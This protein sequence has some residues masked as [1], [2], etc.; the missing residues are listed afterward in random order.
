MSEVQRNLI[1]SC[2]IN[3]DLEYKSVKEYLAIKLDKWIHIQNE[4]EFDTVSNLLKK[5]WVFDISQAASLRESLDKNIIEQSLE[6]I[7]GLMWAWNEWIILKKSDNIIY[8]YNAWKNTKDWNTL[9]GTINEGAE[10]EKS[11]DFSKDTIIF[12]SNITNVD[13]LSREV[14][15]VEEKVKKCNLNIQHT[16]NQVATLEQDLN[17]STSDVKLEN[18]NFDLTYDNKIQSLDEIAAWVIADKIDTDWVVDEVW[19][20][21]NVLDMDVNQN[22]LPV[23]DKKVEEKDNTKK[24]TV[25]KTDT[26][27]DILQEQF[28]FTEKQANIAIE[29]LKNNL[30]FLSQLQSKN[31]DKIYPGESINFTSELLTGLKEQESTPEIEE[32][33]WSYKVGKKDTPS[34]ILMKYKWVN[35]GNVEDIAKELNMSVVKFWE[36]ITLAKTI[37]LIDGTVITKTE[38]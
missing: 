12:D 18:I 36:T 2:N 25:K 19:V 6:W 10:K 28:K 16:Q 26:I 17:K 20:T 23:I 24:Y 7:F 1:E 32:T 33:H 27:W 30:E 21:E 22:Q 8:I 37:T 34:H 29:K 15:L 35:W 9:I 31:I 38:S 3:N 13:H 5:S 11:N 4:Q 14:N